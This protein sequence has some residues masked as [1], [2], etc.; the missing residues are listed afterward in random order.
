M[1]DQTPQP[2]QEPINEQ[3]KEQS[4]E[5]AKEQSKNDSR[6]HK[7]DIRDAKYQRREERREYRNDHRVSDGLGIG[8]TFI[9]IGVVWMMAKLGYL[10]FSII[11][12]LVDLWPLIFVVIGINIVFRKIPYIKLI[13]W[14]TF[15]SAIVGYGFYFAPQDNW[16][17]WHGDNSFTINSNSTPQISGNVPIVGN[18]NV[19]NAQ[20]ELN[21]S[22]GNLMMG[23]SESNLI[24]YDIP[25]NYVDTEVKVVGENAKLVFSEKRKVDI[26]SIKG[27][28]SNYDFYLN[29]GILWDVSV[30][31][32]AAD[33]E[34]DFANVPIKDL[35]INGGAGDFQLTLGELQ[36]KSNVSVNMAAGALDLTVPENVGLKIV[37][38]G[39][40]SDQNFED[41]GLTKLDGAFQTSDYDTAAKVIYIEINSAVS[42]LTLNRK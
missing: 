18:E 3:A 11:G 7:D 24:D 17:S 8:I 34:M 37:T 39:L 9:F 26:G 27:K 32:G 29:K 42:D 1:T 20:L 6:Q 23:A 12:A 22:A 25:Q 13:T 31:V 40:I 33:S 10:N 41:Q 14:V 21:L 36:E 2:E 19:K 5:Q 35:E 4:N 38:N 16:I 28:G 15:L 30:N